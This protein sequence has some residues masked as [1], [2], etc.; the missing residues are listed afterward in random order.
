MVASTTSEPLDLTPYFH[1]PDGDPLTYTAVSDD[2][3]VAVGD[4]ARGSNWL[5]LR[6]VAAGEAIVIV[7]ARDPDGEH[8]S[9]PT[10]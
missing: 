2:A 8:V 3:A 9:Q 4:L 1:D 5:I 10:R 6:G 7:T